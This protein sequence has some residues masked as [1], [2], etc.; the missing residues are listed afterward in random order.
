MLPK[1][2]IVALVVAMSLLLLAGCQRVN[3]LSGTV[4]DF[5][6]YDQVVVRLVDPDT[7]TPTDV[8][9]TFLI[10]DIP[11]ALAERATP[12]AMRQQQLVDVLLDMYRG[13]AVHVA[14]SSDFESIAVRLLLGGRPYAEMLEKAL[15]E[16]VE[17]YEHCN[18]REYCEDVLGN[19]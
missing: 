16:R 10:K 4:V 11:D 18:P 9:A 15:M 19:I 5:L 13:K 14:V 3:L 2:T 17:R 6:R 8:M 1:A 12:D 7:G